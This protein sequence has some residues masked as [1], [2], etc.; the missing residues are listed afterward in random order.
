MLANMRR[1]LSLSYLYWPR[2]CISKGKS[3]FALLAQGQGTAGCI[4]DA[5][6][7]GGQFVARQQRTLLAYREEWS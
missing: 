3:A 1:R 2:V 4:I 5:T 7:M 6:E